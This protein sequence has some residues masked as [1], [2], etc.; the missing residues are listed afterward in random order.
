MAAPTIR[1][2]TAAVAGL[3]ATS[4]SGTAI[5]DLVVVYTFERLGAGT[6]TTLTKHSSMDAEIVNHF[7]NDGSTDGSL[8]A[9]YKVATSSGANSYQGFTSS[10]GTET[11]TG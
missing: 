2:Q 6:A 4:P 11:W 10:V 3:T 7:H 9:A 5:G 1:G 8:A